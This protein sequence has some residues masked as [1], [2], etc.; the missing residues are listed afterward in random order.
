MGMPLPGSDG[1][2]F[3]EAEQ[4]VIKFGR[5][6]FVTTTTAMQPGQKRIEVWDTATKK[7]T[8]FQLFNDEVLYCEQNSYGAF[9]DGPRFKDSMAS[10]PGWNVTFLGNSMM[11][12]PL[13]T[14]RFLLS[15]EANTSAKWQV[16]LEVSATTLQPLEAK[17]VTGGQTTFGRVVFAAAGVETN[18]SEAAKFLQLESQGANRW[19][20]CAQKSTDSGDAKFAGQHRKL[21]LQAPSFQLLGEDSDAVLM[22]QRLPLEELNVTRQGREY[23]SLAAATLA[24][25]GPPA[26]AHAQA[27]RVSSMCQRECF[28]SALTGGQGS[29]VQCYSAD[30]D[31]GICDTS[32]FKVEL[33]L[34]LPGN[35]P[36]A[37]W[38]GIQVA[39]NET[40]TSYTG[41]VEEGRPGMTTDA[42]ELSLDMGT[43]RKCFDEAGGASGVCV[44]VP[45][46]KVKLRAQVVGKGDRLQG[47]GSAITNASVGGSG[48]ASE[49]Y[50]LLAAQSFRLGA[51][52]CHGCERPLAV[53]NKVRALLPLGWLAPF[54]WP[55][56]VKLA[57]A[58]V[59]SGSIEVKPLEKEIMGEED[60]T[61]FD[62]LIE[63][64]EEEEEG[65]DEAEVF[66]ATSSLAVSE[67]EELLASVSG[68]AE[69]KEASRGRKA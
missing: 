36:S 62:P 54:E 67:T 28:N 47:V 43:K 42:M 51:W 22:Y 18:M 16:E 23:L 60:E 19:T 44:E 30:S 57:E 40:E 65:N 25:N 38:T 35:P 69:Y 31:D 12:F 33:D 21:Q 3:M 66:F 14:A 4:T 61:T 24:L 32:R 49:A 13:L 26:D 11:T 58:S 39:S 52:L 45:P 37:S 1:N 2:G 53:K 7:L 15:S 41:Y 56:E 10:F 55:F 27:L 50:K 46:L 63:E 34:T 5:R 8:G 68:S 29:L 20:E 6:L 48:N 59:G 17:V 9:E 64:E